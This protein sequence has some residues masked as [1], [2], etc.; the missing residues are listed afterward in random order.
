MSDIKVLKKEGFVQNRIVKSRNTRRKPK[1]YALADGMSLPDNISPSDMEKGLAA[2]AIVEVVAP[3]PVHNPPTQEKPMGNV[4]LSVDDV[5]ETQRAAAQKEFDDSLASIKI[6][7]DRS[8]QAERTRLQLVKEK[9]ENHQR[10]A[11]LE[12]VILIHPVPDPS[13]SVTSSEILEDLVWAL[14]NEGAHLVDAY[15]NVVSRIKIVGGK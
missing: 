2:G 13:D 9:S 1:C 4:E 6:A 12:D 15:G 11:Q 8:E 14:N 7:Q 10:K 5:F 3:V